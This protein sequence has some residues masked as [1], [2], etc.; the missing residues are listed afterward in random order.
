V[1]ARHDPAWT[2]DGYVSD[3]W[4]PVSPVTGRL[5][6]FHWQ[7]PVASLP[8]DKGATIE[9]AALEEEGA[10]GDALPASNPPKQITSV[11]TVSMEPLLEAE[12]SP[13]QTS[14]DQASAHQASPDHQA[15]ASDP[16]PPA[17]K[18]VPAEP[19]EV[20]T[21]AS[22][23]EASPVA[24]PLF[25]TRADFGGRNPALAPT[26]IPIVRQPDDPGIDD[27]GPRDE[28]AEQIGT[29]KVQAG[30][31]RGFWSRLNG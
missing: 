10:F 13:A 23:T 6:A 17:Q 4:R 25:R 8:S 18:A 1:R 11:N 15:P 12:A 21:E 14:A 26:I 22:A 2:A 3:R 31:W 7:T 19:P 16:E 29:P 9:F 28:F 20:T 30:G 24:T 27:E 5:D